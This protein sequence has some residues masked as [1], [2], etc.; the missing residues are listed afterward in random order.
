[1]KN[2]LVEIPEVFYSFESNQPF[3]QCI[4]CE[5][6]LDE[7]TDYV[8]EKAFKRYSGFSAVDTI[9]DYAMCMSCA[10][11][12]RESLSMDSRKKMD[13]YFLP[14]FHKL[15]QRSVPHA[16]N[17]D[18]ALSSCLITETRLEDI[19]EYQ[20]YAFCRGNKLNTAVSPYMISEAAVE[21]M[22]PL[23]SNETTDFLNGY[24]DK[25]FSPDP[26]MLE[27]MGPKLILV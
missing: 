26:S 17:I 1:M 18:V 3:T 10:L 25:H 22:L 24:F 8:I 27:P 11:H 9:F 16:I 13:E 2:E 5:K 7:N 12:L 23:L 20:I 4:E 15:H 14:H 21:Q 6:A 19:N